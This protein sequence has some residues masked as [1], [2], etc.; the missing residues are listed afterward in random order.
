MKQLV[1]AVSLAAAVVTGCASMSEEECRYVDWRTVGYEDGA[2]GRPASRLGDHRRA[3]AD[4]GVTPDLAA[5]TAGREAGMREFCQAPNGYRVGAS[6]QVY[7]G[8]CPA[9]LAPAFE[10]GY[11]T[12]RE[13]YVRKRRVEET[14]EAI[15]ARQAEIR[16]LEDDLAKGALVLVGDTSS[17]ERRTQAVLDAK[18]AAERIGRLRKEIDDLQAD[19]VRY[20]RELEAY[21]ETVAA[22]Y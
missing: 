20:E 18:Q 19:R 17:P 14:D 5:Y 15:A 9:D 2:A 13:L 7:Y 10:R 3:C 1:V 8:T 12:G 4:H 11:E 21:Q 16:R 6:G 22:T